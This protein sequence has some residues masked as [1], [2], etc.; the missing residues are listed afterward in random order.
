MTMKNQILYVEDEE[1][2][3]ITAEG[4]LQKGFP[5]YKIIIAENS[6]AIDKLIE[7]NCLS[8]EELAIVCTDGHIG[9]LKTGWDVVEGLRENGY[10]GPTIYTGSTQLPADKRHL[11][12][13]Q[14]DYKIGNKLIKMIQKYLGTQPVDYH[15]NEMKR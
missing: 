6:Q 12:S 15:R 11:Y 8:L 1:L 4:D 2:I 10:T 9:G 3:Y 5:K 7:D 14:C 13:E